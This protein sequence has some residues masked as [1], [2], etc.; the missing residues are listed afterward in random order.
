MA[1][2]APVPREPPPPLAG[3]DEWDDEVAVEAFR[4]RLRRLRQTE[5]SGNLFAELRTDGG[6]RRH[7]NMNF[8]ER[9]EGSPG[10]RRR[11]VGPPPGV[12]DRRRR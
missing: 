2:P 9:V 6:F 5:A 3:Y 1:S 10:T 7:F 8:S 12:P 4:L 11:D